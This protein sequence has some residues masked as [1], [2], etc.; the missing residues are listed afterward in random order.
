MKIDIADDFSE[1]INTT[2]T[3]AVGGL[4]TGRIEYEPVVDRDWFAV[5]FEAGELYAIRIDDAHP[6]GNTLYN[7]YLRG[8]HDA[9]G[10]LL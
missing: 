3:V 9:A 10:V 7:P 2:G 1:D 6:E 8:I 4:A 5:E